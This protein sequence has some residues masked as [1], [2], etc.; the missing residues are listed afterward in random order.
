MTDQNPTLPGAEARSDHDTPDVSEQPA[1]SHAAAHPFDVAAAG[2]GQPALG[3]VAPPG[4]VAP[5]ARSA[6]H[7]GCGLLPPPRCSIPSFGAAADN[8]VAATS[9]AATPSLAASTESDASRFMRSG[10]ISCTRE[11]GRMFSP[12]TGASQSRSA[13]DSAATM[14]GS[15]TVGAQSS[16]GAVDDSPYEE[17]DT[18]QLQS[19][20]PPHLRSR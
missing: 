16:A 9:V 8:V 10:S 19:H 3:G 5:A 2:S 12:P 14:L 1:G 7:L 4:G 11:Q 15:A 13:V 18:E 6:A 17:I 20:V